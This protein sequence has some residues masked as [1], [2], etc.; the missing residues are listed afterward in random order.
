MTIEGRPV[1]EH[2]WEK[3]YSHQ[4]KDRMQDAIDDYL[5]DDKVDA[6]QTYEEILSCVEDVIKYHDKEL[7]KATELYNL[8]L[9]HRAIDSLDSPGLTE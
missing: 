5:Q 9:G 8:M 3:E 1:I 7:T 6:R 2:D 4:R